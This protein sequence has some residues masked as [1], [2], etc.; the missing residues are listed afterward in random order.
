M[1][2]SNIGIKTKTSDIQLLVTDANGK[3]SEAIIEKTILSLPF[4]NVKITD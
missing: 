1:M 4:A 3:V 2:T